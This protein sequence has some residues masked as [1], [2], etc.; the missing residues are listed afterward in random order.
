[1][2]DRELW[3]R[4]VEGDAK[5]GN[6]LARRHFVSIHRFFKSKV[7][8]FA[9]ELTQRTFLGFV[10]GGVSFAARG[11]VRAY[12]FGIARKQLLRHFEGRGAGVP[13]GE[14]LNSSVLD[15]D[16]SPSQVLVEL[17]QQQQLL[18]AMHCIPLDHQIVLELFYWEELSVADIAVAIEV[19]PG[20]VKSRLSRAKASLRHELAKVRTQVNEGEDLDRETRLLRDRI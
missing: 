9:D 6:E 10:E 13:A 7:G 1:M 12:L 8:E 4:W 14:I 11:S 18:A 2:D 20:T 19:A 16:P 3:Q 15:L 5:S 17:R